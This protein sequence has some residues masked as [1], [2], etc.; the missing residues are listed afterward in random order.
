M[1]KLLLILLTLNFTV[2]SSQIYTTRTIEIEAG[3]MDKF[4]K[5]VTPFKIFFAFL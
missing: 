3:Q 2:V 5:S 4:I 1:K